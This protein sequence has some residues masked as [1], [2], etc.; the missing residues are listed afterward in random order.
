MCMLKL[1]APNQYARSYSH[2]LTRS[3]THS[4]RQSVNQTNTKICVRIQ[5]YTYIVNELKSPSQSSSIESKREKKIVF[6]DRNGKSRWFHDYIYTQTDIIHVYCHHCHLHRCC[7]KASSA[8]ATA[9]AAT[10]DF[11]FVLFCTAQEFTHSM[12][13]NKQHWLSVTIIS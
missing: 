5:P 9:T 13:M 10:S 12:G 1:I 6:W 7:V 2:A 4:L 8:A 3:L 11:F